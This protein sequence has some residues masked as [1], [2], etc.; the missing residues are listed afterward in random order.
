MQGAGIR[1]TTRQISRSQQQQQQEVS[2]RAEGSALIAPAAR[3][4]PRNRPPTAHRH[5]SPSPALPSLPPALPTSPAHPRAVDAPGRSALRRVRRASV[6]VRPY[7]LRGG[8]INV[9]TTASPH[10]RTR[11]YRSTASRNLSA[12]SQPRVQRTTGAPREDVD[13][14]ETARNRSALFTERSSRGKSEDGRGCSCA[15]RHPPA[16]SSLR[17]RVGPQHVDR[18]HGVSRRGSLSLEREPGWRMHVCSLVYRSGWWHRFPPFSSLLK[19]SVA[20]FRN[21]CTSNGNPFT[22]SPGALHEWAYRFTEW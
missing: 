3:I 16:S 9:I 12:R 7:L 18:E 21:Q 14:F 5:P 1:K 19:P 6:Y 10:E 13:R 22:I 8:A 17:R 20:S 11:A 15:R 2:L 4:N